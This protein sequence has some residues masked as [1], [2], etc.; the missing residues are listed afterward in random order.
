[1]TA[2]MITE[3]WSVTT[4]SLRER[5]AEFARLSRVLAQF[6]RGR[7]LAEADGAAWRVSMATAAIEA[8][9]DALHALGAEIRR[10]AEGC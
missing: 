9:T 3:P 10:I 2:N 8:T 6:E 1:M 7:T 4:A 5:R